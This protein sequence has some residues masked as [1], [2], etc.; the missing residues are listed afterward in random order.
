M[1]HFELP[2]PATMP[3]LRGYLASQ[4]AG[5]RSIHAAPGAWAMEEFLVRLGIE[6]RAQA[7]PDTYH[8]LTP[9]ACFANAAYLV[10]RRRAL[11]YCEGFVLHSGLPIPIHHAWAIDAQNR[12]VDPTLRDPASYEFIGF[13]ITLGE[14]RRW[15]NRHSQS[16][17]D[18]GCG[19][20]LKFMVQHCPAL[21]ELMDEK[22]RQ[23]VV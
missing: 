6:C 21:I 5:W 14:R 20:N 8:R 3:P 9:H 15:T 1:N 4:A 17:F 18:T 19:R 12:V 23:Y 2:S 10:G 11:R 16:V 22:Y 7:L 13:P